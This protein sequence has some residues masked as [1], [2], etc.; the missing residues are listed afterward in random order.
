MSG[1][2]EGRLE[3]QARDESIGRIILVRHGESEGNEVRQFSVSSDI[4]LTARGREQAKAAGRT[5][6]DSFA[7]SA[8][9]AS[10]FRRAQV[11][12]QLIAAELGHAGPVAVE[13]DL[14]ERSIGELAGAPYEAMH[15]HPTYRP[16]RFWEWRPAGGESL[17]DVARR[18][19]AVLDRLAAEHRGRDVVVVSHGGT[20]LALCARVEGGWTRP[21]VARNC[22]IV[23]VRHSP[24]GGFELALDEPR[25]NVARGEGV[26]DATG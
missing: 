19:G 13:H 15:R 2:R 12:A 26:D 18:A 17:E 16:D 21:R 22:E 14:R 23:V 25:P 9:V 24:A 3:S 6:A 10:P 4:E 5:I 20:M 7:T 8:I 1:A 11:T